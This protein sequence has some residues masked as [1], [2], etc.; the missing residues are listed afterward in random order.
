MA[1]AA[2]FDLDAYGTV[3]ASA[4][5]TDFKPYRALLGPK[6]LDT[7]HVVVTDGDATLD[8]RGV[9]EAGLKRGAKLNP[10]PS[11]SKALLEQIALL[12]ETDAA[13]YRTTRDPLASELQATASTSAPRRWRPTCAPCSARRSSR[14]SRS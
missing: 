14:P 8:K 13:D 1:E 11:R 3:V 2:G 4:H 9:R 12:P 5:G 6:G 7:P 10:E